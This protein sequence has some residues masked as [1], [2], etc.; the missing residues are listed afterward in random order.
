M[1]DPVTNQT[2]MVLC[3]LNPVRVYFNRSG[4]PGKLWSVDF[5]RGTPEI[6]CTRVMILEVCS[7]TRY[8][9][10]CVGSKE[11]PCAWLEIPECTVTI[12]LDG[13]VQI[14]GAEQIKK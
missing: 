3:C 5:G 10:T 11:D 4:D 9:S 8:D 1:T 2:A 12:M 7:S 14:S 13:S 6:L